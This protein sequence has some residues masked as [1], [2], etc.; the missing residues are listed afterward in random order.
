MEV[1][2]STEASN[3]D[4][5]DDDRVMTLPSHL[6]AQLPI[7]T[8]SKFDFGSDSDSDSEAEEV[9]IGVKPSPLLQRASLSATNLAGGF[10]GSAQQSS[11]GSTLGGAGSGG[12]A[13]TSSS[14]FRSSSRTSSSANLANLNR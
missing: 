14:I 3:I 11:Q 10:L 1:P 2:N 4:D 7:A 6:S 8:T 9:V 12:L 13:R 5:D